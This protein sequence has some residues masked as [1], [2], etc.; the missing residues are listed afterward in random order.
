MSP[1]DRLEAVP[2]RVDVRETRGTVQQGWHP[3]VI[4]EHVRFDVEGLQSYCFAAAR[5]VVYDL[6][7]VAAA[8]EI[9]DKGR[10]RPAHGWHRCFA[11][12]IPVH[13]PARWQDKAVADTLQDA[14][15]FLTG[16]SWDIRFRA[17]EAPIDAPR[18]AVLPLSI[19]VSAV[20]P[21]SEG[22]D[23]RAVSL[24]ASRGMEGELVP[25]R[26]GSA[27]DPAS[28]IRRQTFAKVPYSVSPID[29]AV[30]SSMR[31][32]AFK[33]AALA[34]LAGDLSSTGRIIMSESIQGALGPTLIPV[35]HAYED[36]RNHPLF[37]DRMAAFL[38]ALLGRR[39]EFE[40]PRLFHTKGET[41]RDALQASC[42]GEFDWRR[43][44]SCWQQSRHVSMDGARRQCGICAACMLRRMSLAA[45]GL[46]DP[47]GT[48][49]WE[50][51]S[52]ST[53]PSAVLPGFDPRKITSAQREYAIAGALH[54]DHLA[55]VARAG[56]RSPEIAHAAYRIARS[57]GLSEQGAATRIGSALNRHRAEWS[58]FRERCG[59]Q[60]FINKWISGDQP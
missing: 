43:T 49:I 22:L 19:P 11:L 48:F 51:L 17:R 50:D 57:L 28:P 41:I 36:Y 4:G 52:A 42:D 30:E 54:M 21:Y 45:A 31:C 59:P 56:E 8:I 2:L 34:G 14:L 13:E 25:I 24:L 7:L 37:T 12:D 29:K 60:S 58:A 53:F 15:E 33:F 20:M 6:M 47:P 38:G 44:R 35:G 5:P 3:C 10:R 46:E 9:C 26:L 32:R 1:Q 27:N 39:F 55:H 16:D 40:F 23:S 18:Y